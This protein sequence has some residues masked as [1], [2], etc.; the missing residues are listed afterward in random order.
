VAVE[1]RDG[2][3]IDRET[4]IAANGVKYDLEVVPAGTRFTGRVRFKNPADY[5]VGLVAQALWMLD[6]GLLSLGG[7]SARGLGWM[8]VTA[9]L[10]RDLPAA[11]LLRQPLGPAPEASGRAAEFLPV[12]TALGAYFE[13]LETLR[14]AAESLPEPLPPTVPQKEA[15]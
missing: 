12:A 6:E 15:V 11:E 14:R 7:K 4:R 1:L 8:E 5:E 9:T 2:V 3:G 10:P 13:S